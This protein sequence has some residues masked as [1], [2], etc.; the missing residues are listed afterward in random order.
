MEH[1]KAYRCFCTPERLEQ[2]NKEKE[3]RKEPPGYDRHCRSLSTDEIARNLAEGKRHVIRFKAPL[4]G[5]T[6]VEDVIRGETAFE[7][8]T[9]QDMVL[10]KSD[11][12]P[13]YHLAVVID[14]HFM[15]ISH[16]M[17]AVE[18]FPS[19]PLHVLIWR[20]FG[21]EMPA[22]AHLPVM[23][24]P[25]G[26]GK[27]SKRKPPVDQYGNVIPV[28][29]HDYIEQ[30]YLPEAMVN[31]LTNIGWSFGEEREIFT[32]A[33]TLERFRLEDINPANSAFPA[34]KLEWYNGQYIRALDV[35]DL[36]ARLRPFLERAGL[37]VEEAKLLA[38]AP[39]VQTRLKRLTDVVDLAG[40]LFRDYSAFVPADA[41]TLI[42][43]KMDAAS[44]IEILRKSV[45]LI[46][47]LPSFDTATLLEAFSAVTSDWGVN[48]SQLFGLLRVAMSAQ[49][50]STP[51]F[52]TMEILG[53][54]E[55]LRRIGLAIRALG[56]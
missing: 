53:K 51:T 41:S 17:R 1:D 7:N 24:N 31:F 3:A 21:W 50:I 46:G 14:D 47:M 48:N 52:E 8:S 20:A 33:E 30:G 36:A 34:D 18:W 54:E 5:Q 43:K 44:S 37:V 23:L 2:V 15:Q 25:N 19:F 16:V 38:V 56:G 26:K 10:L 4:E 45:E 11:G 35:K 12:F 9:I 49:K 32:V 13:T 55:S 22:F 6:V 29:V 42:Q 28:M 40:F 39:V 27:M